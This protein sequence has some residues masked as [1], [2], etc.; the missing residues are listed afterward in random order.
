MWQKKKTGKRFER[1]VAAL[2]VWATEGAEVK[3][4]DEIEGRQVDVSIRFR[5]GFYDYLVVIECK[6]Y[7]G[8]VPGEKVEAFAKRLGKLKADKG[9][10]VSRY[11]FQ[12]GF[13]TEL[14]RD[15]GIGLYT[16]EEIDES[17][18]DKVKKETVTIGA[19]VFN[20][21][22]VPQPGHRAPEIPDEKKVLPLVRLEIDGFGAP[23]SL[24]QALNNLPSL[25]ERE[26]ALK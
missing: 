10:M 6:D 7:A 13:G 19:N 25:H 12:Q 8:S 1:L 2:N 14:A 11:G 26:L 20:V 3:W 5:K 23:M 18:P 21:R 9:V 4:D 15:E 22:F 17:W 16:L 24:E